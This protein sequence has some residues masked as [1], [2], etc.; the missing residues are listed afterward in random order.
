MLRIFANA[1][2]MQAYQVYGYQVL[3]APSM[4]FFLVITFGKK[5]INQTINKH[6]LIE[7][8]TLVTAILL[9]T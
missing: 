1:H 6:Q 4:A 2:K 8:A 5:R 3:K 9:T 7:I